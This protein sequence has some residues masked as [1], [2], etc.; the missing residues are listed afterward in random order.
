MHRCKD[1]RCRWCNPVCTPTSSSRM[2]RGSFRI[3]RAIAT[4]C[5]SP[6]LS[7]RP[8]SPTSVSYPV[9]TRWPQVNSDYFL[10]PVAVLLHLCHPPCSHTPAWPCGSSRI[11]LWMS[12]AT[13]ALSTSSLLAVMRPYRM[14][15]PMVSLKRTVSWG[16]T[17]M[18]DLRE[19][20]RTLEGEETKV[21]TCGERTASKSSLCRSCGAEHELRFQMFRMSSS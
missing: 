7:F 21:Q 13:A 1:G 4:L 12:A 8:R 16:T 20:W 15:L 2:I 5:F 18:W 11:L 17:P 6:P 3:V 10:V 14:L 19:D 9:G